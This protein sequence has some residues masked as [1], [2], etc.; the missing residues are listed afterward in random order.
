[1]HNHFWIIDPAREAGPGATA[2]TEYAAALVVAIRHLPE[3]LRPAVVYVNTVGVGSAYYDM[4]VQTVARSASP[5]VVRAL[6]L[7]EA[8]PFAHLLEALAPGATRRLVWQHRSQP[9]TDP[10]RLTGQI[11]YVAG[12]DKLPLHLHQQLEADTFAPFVSVCGT[13]RRPSRL[14]PGFDCDPA[15]NCLGVLVLPPPAVSKVMLRCD[16]CGRQ[17]VP[18]NAQAG[19]PCSYAAGV[20]LKAS[21][22]PPHTLTVLDAGSPCPGR[23]AEIAEPPDRKPT[24]LPGGYRSVAEVPAVICTFCSATSNEQQPGDECGRRLGKDYGAASVTCTGTMK[25][26]AVALSAADAVRCDVCGLPP[27]ETLPPQQPGDK[28]N[29]RPAHHGGLTCPGTFTRLTRPVITCDTC[30][31]PDPERQEGEPCRRTGTIEAMPNLSCAGTLRRLGLTLP[32]TF[33]TDGP[34]DLRLTVCS[35]CGITAV[36]LVPGSYC[37]RTDRECYGQ[38]WLQHVADDLRA[39]SVSTAYRD[40]RALLRCDTCGLIP[41]VPGAEEGGLCP[42]RNATGTAACGGTLKTDPA[43]RAPAGVSRETLSPSDL[44]GATPRPAVSLDV[45]QVLAARD[46]G[47]DPQRQLLRC[48][49]FPVEHTAHTGYMSVGDPCPRIVPGTVAD[50]VEIVTYASTPCPGILLVSPLPEPEL[51]AHQRPTMPLLVCTH[52]PAHTFTGTAFRT[53]EACPRKD[54]RERPCPGQLLPPDAEQHPMPLVCSS[55]S[56]HTSNTAEMFPGQD[57]PFAADMQP[58]ETCLGVMRLQPST[59]NPKPKT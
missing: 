28:C 7:V 23:I 16:K 12:R 4:L 11:A 22:A 48:N 58:D 52:N 59:G 25:R 45:L 2:P 3:P 51:L 56:A 14:S 18:E 40:G 46:S 17:P 38:M 15:R 5:L 37:V 39:R 9:V 6:N 36:G 53:Q 1:V 44:T 43:L 24:P 10:T 49:V 21:E 34:V 54:A 47:L 42:Y 35:V 31:L 20:K 33:T 30:G 29:R 41:S 19:N 32:V 50:D 57:C 13:C 55:D 26:F 27:A 8:E